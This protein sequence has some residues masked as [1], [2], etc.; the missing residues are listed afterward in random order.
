MCM[1]MCMCDRENS[2]VSVYMSIGM[3]R[4]RRCDKRGM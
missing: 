1:E 4:C 2:D 3:Y